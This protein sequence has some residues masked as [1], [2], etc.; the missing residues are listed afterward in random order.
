MVLIDNKIKRMPVID[1][2]G[3]VAGLVSRRALLN[4]MLREP[5]PPL[6]I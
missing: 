3:Q 5:E 6:T 4:G 1:H 2:N